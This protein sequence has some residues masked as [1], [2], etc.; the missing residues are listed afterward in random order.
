MPLAASAAVG[1]ETP[2]GMALRL[3]AAIGD[4]VLVPAGFDD[5]PD[6][7]GQADGPLPPYRPAL[8][9]ALRHAGRMVHADALPVPTNRDMP[10]MTVDGL[11][12]MTRQ[13][14][15]RRGT[16]AAA[17]CTGQPFHHPARAGPACAA[18]G[19]T[20]QQFCLLSRH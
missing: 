19:G 15:T 5:P 1:N 8:H 2:P 4:G 3:A 9:A 6:A 12:V 20:G 13:G 14:D 16:R 7:P 10:V 18:A 17:P 11:T